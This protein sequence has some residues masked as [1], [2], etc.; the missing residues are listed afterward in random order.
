MNKVVFRET[1][2]SQALP[3]PLDWGW[4]EDNQ[5]V[6]MFNIY[7]SFCLILPHVEMFQMHNEP[8]KCLI[9]CH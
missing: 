6:F 5:E 3:E 4:V 9:I 1:Q 7:V 8:L 2:E